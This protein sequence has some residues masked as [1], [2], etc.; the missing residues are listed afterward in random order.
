MNVRLF[1]FVFLFLAIVG[2]SKKED[3]PTSSTTAPVIPSVTFTGPSKTD[4]DPT[5]HASAAANYA[6]AMTSFFTPVQAFALLPAQQSGNQWRW[7][8]QSGT[9]TVIFQAQKNTDG[10][11][12]WQYIF[13]GTEGTNTYNNFVV[14]QGTISADGKSGEWLIYDEDTQLLSNYYTYQTNAQGVK[15][16][17]WETK[18]SQGTATIQKIVLVNNP[19]GTGSTDVYELYNSVLVKVEHI[20]WAAN[21]SGSWIEYTSAGVESNSGSWQ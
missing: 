8:I 1:A 16:G 14:W 13:N 20:E 18:N 15:T 10:S 3:S 12:V 4:T 5:Y 2:C 19:D 21:G 9:L 17:I 11:Y 7:S 6:S